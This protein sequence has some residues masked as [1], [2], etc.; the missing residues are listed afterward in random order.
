[1]SSVMKRLT[2]GGGGCFSDSSDGK[3][4]ACDTGGLASVPGSGRP[5]EKGMTTRSSIFAW[6]IPWTEGPGGVQ[7]MGSQRVKHN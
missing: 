5:L 4:S 3:G 6:S 7:S 1:M 2:K